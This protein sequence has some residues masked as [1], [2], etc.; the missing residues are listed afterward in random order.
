SC[1]VFGAPNSE[2]LGGGVVPTGGTVAEEPAART[3]VTFGSLVVA[4]D[5]GGADRPARKS[6]TSWRVWRVPRCSGLTSGA[7]GSFSRRA[8]R[9]STRLI[10]STPRSASRLSRR[11]RLSGG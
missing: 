5:S 9:I 10:E 1:L 4:G 2:R 11:S 3:V 7:W 6:A 8:E